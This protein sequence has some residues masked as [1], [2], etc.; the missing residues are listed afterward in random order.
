MPTK[1]V[2]GSDH[3]GYTLKEAIS[4]Y[5]TEKK[6]VFLDLGTSNANES[7]DYPEIAFQVAE[8]VAKNSSYQG[9]LICGTGIGMS[10][11]ANKI[12]GI[13]AALC[14]NEYTATMA[15]QHNDANILVLGARVLTIAEGIAIVAQWRAATFAG[16]R[17][18]RRLEQIKRRENQPAQELS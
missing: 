4:A 11:A 14:H 2:L 13:R 7:V 1:I 16:D 8:Q 3:G 18:R 17:H 15:K 10:I 9:I 6:V 5:L 12:K